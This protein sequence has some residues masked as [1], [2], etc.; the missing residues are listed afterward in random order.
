[1]PIVAKHQL[2]RHPS[3][4]AHGRVPLGVAPAFALLGTDDQVQLHLLIGVLAQSQEPVPGFMYGCRL[5]A[6]RADR[7]LGAH[8][9]GCGQNHGSRHPMTWGSNP[10]YD[11]VTCP[12]CKGTMKDDMG[13]W[14]TTHME[15]CAAGTFW[16]RLWGALKYGWGFARGRP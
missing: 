16:R 11:T 13:C 15:R 14:P 6:L 10:T 4:Q 2:G 12:W 1:M 9:Q 5:L 3:H 8:H 7:A